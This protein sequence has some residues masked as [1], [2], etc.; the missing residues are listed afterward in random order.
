MKV[1]YKA[2]LFLLIFLGVERFC[3]W[4]TDGFA[5]QKV[6]TRM[7]GGAQKKADPVVIEALS[8]KFFYLASGGSCYAFQSADG[9]YVLKLFKQHHLHGKKRERV[10]ESCKLAFQEFKEETG[11]LCVHLNRDEELK[12]SFT[13]VDKLGIAH[14]LFADDVQFLLQKKAEMA[15]SH[16]DRLMAEN[17]IEGAKRAVDQIL[18]LPAQIARKGIK[19]LDPNVKTNLGFIGDRA[20]KIDVG[21]FVR[22]AR[23]TDE[24]YVGKQL[25][26][27]KRQLQNWLKSHYPELYQYL[28]N[29][30][31]K[32]E[33]L[34]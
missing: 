1:V 22:D 30:D 15:Y 20:V 2:A 18:L 6:L 17:N 8:Q 24:R 10:F 19:D 25:V 33:S 21:P 34:R 29:Q 3:H 32:D 23:F 12:T 11:L 26:K 13:L 9:K 5:L 7:E 28:K 14:L 16:I 27:P 4:Q 31:S